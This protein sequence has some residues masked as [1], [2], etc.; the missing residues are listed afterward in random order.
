MSEN[1]EKKVRE[2]LVHLTRRSIMSPA[3]AW[4][5]RVMAVLLGLLVCGIVAFLLV[6]KL[7]QNPGRIGE[8]YYTFIKGSFSTPRKAWKFFKDLAILLCIALALT[9][10][11]RMR[12]WNTGAEGQT[13]MG[14][15]GA[16]AVAFYWGGKIPE[17]LLLVLMFAA[18][19][20]CGAAWG[21]IP[22]LFKAKWNTNETLFTLMMNYVASYVVAYFLVVWVPSGSSNLGK[23]KY[24]KLPSLGHDY[25]LIILVTLLLTIGLH[26]YLNYSKHGYELN[27][28]GESIRTAKYVGIGVGKVIIRTM[29]LSG[30]LCGLAGYLIAA[31]LDQTITTESVGGQGFT[32]IMVCWL[33]KFHPLGM[34]LTAGLVTLLDHGAAQ[35]SQDFS[36]ASDFPDVVVGIILFFVI[37]SEFFI[38]YQLHFRGHEKEGSVK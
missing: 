31:G 25:L 20:L 33:A 9:P 12:F 16:I 28:V 5:I 30:A 6:D 14:I 13:L 29:I 22:A 23:L 27:V 35:I 36:V 17:G 15:W 38:N 18:S 7:R 2:P 10:A 3:K 34:I 4:G 1:R 8:F 11:F 24:G 26:I 19:L 37:G 32:A 21:L